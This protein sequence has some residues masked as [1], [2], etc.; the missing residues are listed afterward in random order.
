[1]PLPWRRLHRGDWRGYHVP[2]TLS[3]WKSL[4]FLWPWTRPAD[5]PA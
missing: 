2:G 4:R 3:L 5:L 1:M